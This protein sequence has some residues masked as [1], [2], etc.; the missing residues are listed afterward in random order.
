MKFCPDVLSSLREWLTPASHDTLHGDFDNPLRQAHVGPGDAMA[1]PHFTMRFVTVGP[2]G[3]VSTVNMGDGNGAGGPFGAVLSMLLNGLAGG[4]GGGGGG[5][6]LGADF[7]AAL[8][9]SMAPQ[10]R[11]VADS[12]LEGLPESAVTADA[13]GDGEVKAGTACSV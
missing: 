6:G 1:H 3:N 2:D 8:A 5:G 4:G 11:P 10:E 12:V 7:A 9:A 13:E